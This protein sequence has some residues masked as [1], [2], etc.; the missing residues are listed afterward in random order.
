MF[1]GLS[2]CVGGGFDRVDVGRFALKGSLGTGTVSSVSP[3]NLPGGLSFVPSDS[4]NNSVP[5]RNLVLR[6]VSKS[7][8]G[9]FA[10]DP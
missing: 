8:V 6:L 5:L 2:F 3:M 1:Y 10:V 4:V 9:S 7:P